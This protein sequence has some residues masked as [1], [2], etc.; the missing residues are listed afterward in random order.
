[1]HVAV[2]EAAIAAHLT[3]GLIAERASLVG[4]ADLSG[5]PAHVRQSLPRGVSIAVA[6]DP[7]V[8]A[9]IR[10]GPNRRYYAEYVRANREL[11]RL[12]RVAGSLLE[13]HGF[14][15]V[16]A[17][18]TGVGLDTPN[19]STP[20]PHK[21]V[22]TRAGLGWIGKC[23]LLVTEGYGS[24][25]R[26]T[27]V[28]TDAPLETVAPIDASRCG[29]CDACV[30]HCPGDAPSGKPWDV[31]TDRDE[32]FDVHACREAAKAGAARTGIREIVCGICIAVCPWTVRY[33]E[34]SDTP[35]F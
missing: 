33:I 27:S 30:M 7:S 29:S 35:G 28:L 12:G 16:A 13:R 3:E 26:L 14:R 4:Y 9:T 8:V 24:A 20:L 10:S 18:V 15:A 21:T 5:L 2:T 19:L 32:F 31:H 34:S 17:Q 23:A 25:L 11:T 1:M 6:L 22:A